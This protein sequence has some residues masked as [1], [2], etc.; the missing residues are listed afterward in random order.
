M[1]ANGLD[2]S[3]DF[4]RRPGAAFVVGGVADSGLRSF[5]SSQHGS[6]VA[7]TY[8]RNEGRSAQL[9]DHGERS[10]PP[11]MDDRTRSAQPRRLLAGHRRHRRRRRWHPH[12]CLRRRAPRP[13][14]TPVEGEPVGDAGTARRRRIRLLR[15]RLAGACPICARPRAASLPSPPLRPAATR[16][17]T[18]CRRS[19][20]RRSRPPSAASLPKR[21]ASGF[22]PTPSARDAHRRDGRTA[23]GIGRSRRGGP[24][25][26][27]PTSPCAGSVRPTTSPRR[28][29]SSPRCGRSSSPD[30]TSTSTAASPSS[31]SIRWSVAASAGSSQHPLVRRSIRGPTFDHGTRPF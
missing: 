17:V 7:F 29:A 2:L 3:D 14:E 5:A 30:S 1:T 31:A 21:A 16:C 22:G 13:A 26:P 18:A 24:R 9:A 25:R 10:W 12:A 19:R 11:G 6:H 20:K 8:R 27:G 4:T 28:C 23:D 15:R